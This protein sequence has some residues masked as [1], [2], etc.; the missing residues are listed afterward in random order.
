M[1]KTPTELSG[2]HLPAVKRLPQ[3]AIAARAGTI[4]S[5]R[6]S[7]R[8]VANGMAGRDRWIGPSPLSV[9]GQGEPGSG[10]NSQANS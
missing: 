5:E 7:N 8:N 4:E 2:S 10:D 1:Y 6:A 9:A 3:Q